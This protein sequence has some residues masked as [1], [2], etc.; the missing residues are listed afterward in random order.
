MICFECDNCQRLKKDGDAWI[1]G[2]AAEAVGVAAARREISFLSAWDDESAAEPMAVHFCCERCS[3]Q[4]MQRLF[5]SEAP[6]VEVEELPR[7]R[8]AR[9]VPGAVVETRTNVA[10]RKKSAA[11]AGP[12]TARRPQKRR[13]A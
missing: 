6:R 12:R 11:K 1:L 4:Y 2:F 10:R 13:R 7:K 9:V 8:V 5:G 3:R